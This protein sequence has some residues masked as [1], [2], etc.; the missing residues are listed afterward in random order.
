MRVYCLKTFAAYPLLFGATFAWAA[1]HTVAVGGSSGDYYNTPNLMFSPRTLTIAAGDTVTF[2]NIGGHHNVHA[3]DE[4]FR[5][6]AG[7][8]GAGGNGNPVDDAWSSTVTFSHPGTFTYHCDV[9]GSM[10]MTGTITVQGAAT[11]GNVPITNG[12]TGSWVNPAGQLGLGVE[13]LAGGN[14]VVEGYT[15]SAAGGQLWIGG[16]GAIVGGDH[17]PITVTTINGAGA[18]FPPNFNA[19]QTQNTPWGTLTLTFTD[20]NTGTA[21][22]AS[23]VAGYGSGSMPI[24][25]LTQPAG[26]ACP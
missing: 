20:C 12:F 8:D 14:M 4:S 25:R 6:A 17:A 26:L 22:W 5:C 16:V 15:Y 2:T 7:C 9:H 11:G 18:R 3:D 21:A 13:V 19:A 10:G 24:I 23:T 1:P